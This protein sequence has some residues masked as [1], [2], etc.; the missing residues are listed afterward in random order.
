[1]WTGVGLD[2]V[3]IWMDMV[4]RDLMIRFYESRWL[5]WMMEGT[6]SDRL[7]WIESDRFFLLKRFGRRDKI[8]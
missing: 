6:E 4:V 3:L 2:L 8:D 1:M 7:D 5:E